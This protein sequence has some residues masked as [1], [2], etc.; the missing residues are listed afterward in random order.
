ML[1]GY[2]KFPWM[3]ARNEVD[4]LKKITTIPLAIPAMPQR[5]TYVI[6]LLKKMLELD[7]EKRISWKEIMQHPII[8]G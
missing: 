5:S 3:G 7:E 6:D 8:T 1:Y 2:A 4:L